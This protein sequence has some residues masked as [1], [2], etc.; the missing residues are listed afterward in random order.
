MQTLRPC[1]GP[2]GWNYFYYQTQ[3]G[4]L[5]LSAETKQD[6]LNPAAP[7]PHVTLAGEM[8]FSLPL[9]EEGGAGARRRS[10]KRVPES[11]RERLRVVTGGPR[12]LLESF[13]PVNCLKPFPCHPTW[14][15][16]DSL[17]QPL[18]PCLIPVLPH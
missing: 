10:A 1:E 8:L 17:M 2:R 5:K 16:P 6:K 4:L 13:D 18:G 3:I 11:A 15:G 14:V 12:S 7:G 9:W